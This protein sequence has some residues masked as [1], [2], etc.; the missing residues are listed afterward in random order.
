MINIDTGEIKF[1]GLSC[2]FTNNTT[3]PGFLASGVEIVEKNFIESSKITTLWFKG[4]I[5]GANAS[6]VVGFEG[7]HICALRFKRTSSE[8]FKEKYLLKPIRKGNLSMASEV[9]HILNEKYRSEIKQNDAWLLR[10]IG[11]PPP[12][13]YKWGK[14]VSHEAPHTGEAMVS[15]LFNQ[16]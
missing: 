15:I 7:E 5:D 9:G 2:S 10:T 11:H 3:L 12:Y 14:I 4:S 6:F 8:A 13:E 1:D 16:A